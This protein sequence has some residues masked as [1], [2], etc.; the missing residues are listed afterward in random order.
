M[1]ILA[2][3]LKEIWH[4][5]VNFVLAVLAVVAAVALFIGFFTAGEASN[6]E[7]AR[8]MLAM[9]Y[10]LHIIAR[11]ADP[12]EFLITGF[13]DQTI[14]ED[15]LKRLV[16]VNR[17][18]ISYNHLLPSLQKQISWRGLNVI[19]TGVGSEVWPAGSKKPPISFEIAPG[20][21]YVGYRVAR[22]LKLTEGDHV[23]LRGKSFVV[24]RC[25][26]ESGGPDDMRLQCN[27][28]DAQEILGLPGRKGRLRGEAAPP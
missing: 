22:I 9:G 13:T 8:L 6:R 2:L 14:P 26:A 11:D 12:N 1:S 21:L 18:A 4:R 24:R 10:N 23:E 28:R 16:A 5:K 7:T 20:E 27:L 3:I 19:L 17:R 25:L 15:Y